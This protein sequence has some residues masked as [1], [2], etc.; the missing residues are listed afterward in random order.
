MC[1][2]NSRPIKKGNLDRINGKIT[3]WLLPLVNMS[4][5]HLLINLS[6]ISFSLKPWYITYVKIASTSTRVSS[7][8]VDDF[9]ASSYQ[10]AKWFQ[11][12]TI[13]NKAKYK[14][15]NRQEIE[16]RI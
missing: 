15:E 4:W 5:Y 7:E 3:L 13:S 9:D 12:G 8:C 11:E 16:G 14:Q 1:F 10:F 2:P 6:Y